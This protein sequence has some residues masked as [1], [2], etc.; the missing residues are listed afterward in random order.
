MMPSAALSHFLYNPNPQIV[1]YII[2]IL[3]LQSLTWMS[4]IISSITRTPVIVI[5]LFR[6]SLPF[7]EKPYQER[8]R[9]PKK[10]KM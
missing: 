3:R 9:E 10:A 8:P 2:R 1:N 7:S 4:W 6:F 5:I